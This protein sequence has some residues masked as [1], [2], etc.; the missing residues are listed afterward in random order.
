MTRF[1]FIA[2]AVLAV[3]M[4]MPA[5]AEDVSAGAMKITGAWARATPKGASVGGGYLTITNTGTTPDKLYGGASDA[6]SRVEIHT[7]S[8]DN[9]VM[10]MRKAD[11]GVEIQPGQSITFSPSGYHLMFIGL[12][13]PF[14]E[15]KHIMATLQFE[16]AGKANVDFAVK[17]LGAQGPGT[18][19]PMQHGQ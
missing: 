4:A 17:G 11:N 2:A 3:L 13:T 16:K 19:M 9:G 6:S 1:A 18:A 8:M 15:G 10:R 14:D 5:Q 12:K 7:M